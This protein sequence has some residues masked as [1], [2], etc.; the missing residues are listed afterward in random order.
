MVARSDQSG[1][2]SSVTTQMGL[3]H[4]WLAGLLNI[5]PYPLGLGYLYLE[6]SFN[7]MMAFSLAIA[8][9]VAAIIGSSTTSISSSG[10]T[11]ER[12]VATASAP[13]FLGLFTAAHGWRS[14]VAH[15]ATLGMQP[16]DTEGTK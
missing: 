15:N 8:A 1:E 11:L 10:F 2:Y 16:Q 12:V 4:P 14:A 5:L 9:G 13:V 7:F 6:N 3:K